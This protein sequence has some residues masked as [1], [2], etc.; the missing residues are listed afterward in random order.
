MRTCVYGRL[1]GGRAFA[2]AALL[3]CSSVGIA[4]GA[5]AWT[6][7]EVL[8]SVGSAMLHGILTLPA[9]AGPFPAV[10]L[11]SGSL[12]PSTGLR[13][14]VS[15][16]IHVEHARRLVEDGFAVLRY[17]PPGIGRSTGTPGYESL[18]V[19]ADEALA[20]L[21]SIRSHRAV[22]AARVGMLTNSQG[23]WVIQLAAAEHPD[24]IAF[25]VTLSGSGVSVAEQQVYGIEMQS[26]AGGLSE[27]EVRKAVLFGRLLV[28]WQLTRPVFE[29]EN[30]KEAARLGNGI[31]DRFAQ[32]VYRGSGEERYTNA[33]EILRQAKNEPWARYLYLDLVVA[34]LERIPFDQ[35]SLVQ[36]EAEKTLLADPGDFLG[37]VKCPVLAFF[38]AD[39]TLQPTGKS[40]ALYR[41]Y[42]ARAGNTDVTIVVFPHTGHSI[43]GYWPAYWQELSAWLTRRFPR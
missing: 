20:A 5:A 24:E 11:V 42:L 36:R 39:D 9:G 25:I 41:E 29:E 19:R 38:G 26:R 1:P 4:A 31:W 15:S 8:F 28:D 16:A 10:V 23:A 13:D 14:G 30:R 21:R 33:L 22:D 3:L 12:D 27:D 6:E 43:E 7:E 40:V 34:Q 35:V 32:V 37:K 2:L 17:D 18:E